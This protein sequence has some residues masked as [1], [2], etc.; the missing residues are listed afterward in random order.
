[1]YIKKKKHTA[2]KSCKHLKKVISIKKKISHSCVVPIVCEPMH[3]PFKI[4]TMMLLTKPHYDQLMLA[5]M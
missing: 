1:M 4:E 2:C 3:Q 5:A